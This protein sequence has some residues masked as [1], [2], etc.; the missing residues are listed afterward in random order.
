MLTCR[1]EKRLGAFHLQVDLTAGPHITALFGPSG[2]GKS[3][4]LQAIAGLVRPDRGVI[5][6]NGRTLFDGEAGT[7]LPPQARRVGYVPQHYALFPH[8]TVLQNVAYGLH[9]LPRRERRERAAAAIAA[10]G[11]AGLESRRPGELSGGQQQ[12]VALARALVTRPEVLLLDE[13]FAALDD[14]TRRALHGE[15]LA[16]LAEQ[17]IPTLLVTHQLEEAYALSRTIAVYEAGRVVQLGPRTAVF[18]RPAT[19]EAAA[20]MGFHNRLEGVV[21]AVDGEGARVRVGPHQL[22]APAGDARPGERVVCAI[23]PEHVMLVRKDRPLRAPGDTVLAGEIVEEIDYGGDVLLLFRSD[24]PGVE[25]QVSL[26][27]YVYERLHV[28]EEKRWDVVLR[29]AYLRTYRV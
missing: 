8:M 17:Q 15:L 18:Q 14:A 6:L 21:A 23:R 5:R 20:Q 9:R 4:T 22:L 24:P 28:A 16:V 7:N 2:S 12:R 13:P 10:V 27:G 3:L 26:P 29:R 11:L 25:L 1:I 19:L